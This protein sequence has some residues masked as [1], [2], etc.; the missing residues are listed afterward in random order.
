[1][2][3]FEE[4][5]AQHKIIC[6]K[7]PN[8]FETRRINEDS[9]KLSI[10]EVSNVI[11]RA[12][13]GKEFQLIDRINVNDNEEFR[14]L[15]KK[16]FL[17]TLKKGVE[18]GITWGNIELVDISLDDGIR[19]SENATELEKLIVSSKEPDG[20]FVD[21]L[22]SHDGRRFNIDCGYLDNTDW[23]WSFESEFKIAKN[24]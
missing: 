18:Y 14:Q 24:P 4:F 2:E 17:Q 23:G 13:K 7:I 6:V 9:R 12:F 19:F 5:S 20:Y 10:K 8:I 1:M 15:F 3:P 11:F 21:I 22:I 16:S